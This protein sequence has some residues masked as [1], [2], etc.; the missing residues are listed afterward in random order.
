MTTRQ[1]TTGLLSL[2]AGLSDCLGWLLLHGVF[3][4]HITGNLVVFVADVARGRTPDL[5]P[6]LTIPVFILA[7]AAATLLALRFHE[8]LAVQRW[9]LCGQTVLLIAAALSGANLAT[10]LLAV[11]AMALQN[12]LLHLLVA[13]APS[14]AVMTGNVVSAT[15]A[16]VRLAVARG[17]RQAA[18]TAF[19]NTWP[20]LAGFTIG[21]VLAGVT[22]N[23][24]GNT[25]WFI[26]AA[27]SLATTVWLWTRPA[28]GTR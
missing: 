4:A 13:P 21:C 20:L 2:I 10:L 22:A 19:G 9:L 27:V 7:T 6:L 28:G 8:D 16:L 15:I 18:A 11:C 25:A 14:T 1:L 26:P 12:S 17:D 24:I 23:A 5:G 3:T